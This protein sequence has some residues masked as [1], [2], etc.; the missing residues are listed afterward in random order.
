MR[1]L[2]ALVLLLAAQPVAAT[3]GATA[4]TDILRF[5]TSLS[6]RFVAPSAR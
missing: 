5:H 3:E 2:P 4:L 6:Q 1:G